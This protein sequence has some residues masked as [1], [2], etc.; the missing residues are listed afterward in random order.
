MAHSSWDILY[1]IRNIMMQILNFKHAQHSKWDWFLTGKWTW[2]LC[3]TKLQTYLTVI[4]VASLQMYYSSEHFISLITVVKQEIINYV[5][6]LFS[7]DT[8]HWT[9]FYLL[10]I[11]WRS[12]CHRWVR[13]RWRDR[14]VSGKVWSYTNPVMQQTAMSYWVIAVV[15]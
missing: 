5:I 7:G 9:A 14:H 6:S 10:Y 13:A 8:W 3:A 12:N 4:K 11:V 1:I 15:W 2:N